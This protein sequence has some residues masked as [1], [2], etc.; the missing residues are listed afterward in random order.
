MHLTRLGF[1]VLMVATLAPGL[2]PEGRARQQPVPG[3]AVTIESA[4]WETAPAGRWS[5]LVVRLSN[6]DVKPFAGEVRLTPAPPDTAHPAP[7]TSTFRLP[8]ALAPKA[9]NDLSV[10]LVTS[11]ARFEVAVHDRHGHQVARHPSPVAGRAGAEGWVG[12]LSDTPAGRGRVAPGAAVSTRFSS[13]ADFPTSV[14]GLR[15]LRAVVIQGFDSATLG[16]EQMQALRDFVG[17]GGALVLGGGAEAAR[18]VG[19]LPEDLTPLRPGGLST[20]SL[21]PVAELTG[22]EGADEVTVTVGNVGFGRP[23]L[24]GRDGPPLVVEAPY[25]SGR[26]LQIAFDPVAEWAKPGARLVQPALALAL[27]RAGA[28]AAAA[29]LA[30][31]QGS[32]GSHATPGA[33]AAGVMEVTRDDS[34][35]PG[36]PGWALAGLGVYGAAVLAGCLALRARGTP[37]RLWALVPAGAVGVAVIVAVILAGPARRPVVDDKVQVLRAG[38]T[39]MVEIQSWHRVRAGGGDLGLRV[40]E[41][42]AVWVGQPGGPEPEM[43]DPLAAVVGDEL[44]AQSP[45]GS[46]TISVGG[47]GGAAR[48]GSTGVRADGWPLGTVRM[49]ET[50]SVRRLGGIDARLRLAGGR[51]VGEVSNRGGSQVRHLVVRTPDG[52]RAEVARRLAPGA[53]VMVDVPLVRPGQQ[54]LDARPDDGADD[55]VD[56][57]SFAVDRLTP[58][59]GGLQILG[60]LDPVADLEGGSGRRRGLSQAVMVATANLESSDDLAPGLV[61]AR[62]VYAGP[63]TDGPIVYEMQVPPGVTGPLAL[64]A[65]GVKSGSPPATVEVFD[66]ASRRWGARQG[67]AEGG[68]EPLAPNEV[69]AGAVLVRTTGPGRLEGLRVVKP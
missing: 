55:R 33:A 36:R 40:P 4:L 1:S 59:G 34:G 12:V 66:W 60:E 31:D 16:R 27:G 54:P 53:T 13:A 62:P 8:V 51:L 25:G 11:D 61:L 15:G 30:A 5:P 39:G 14:T 44:S 9:T 50:V 57:Y 43:A 67:V 2:G 10:P 68:V 49:V 47:T 45:P 19:P 56:L 46:E 38:S 64:A 7:F 63:S 52:S 41:G 48:T 29:Q 6:G 20:A 28:G 21:A 22:L 23:V 17:L 18:T 3:A 58:T 35:S 24:R 37:L 42:S 65:T 26:I 32:G 69:D